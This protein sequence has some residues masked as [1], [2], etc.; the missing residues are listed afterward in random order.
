MLIEVKVRRVIVD[1]HEGHPLVVLQEVGGERMLSIFIGTHDAVSIQRGVWGVPWPRPFTQDVIVSVIEALGGDVYGVEITGLVGNTYHA[2]INV[3]RGSEFFRID[4]R[5]SDAIAIVLSCRPVR[6]IYVEEKLF[7]TTGCAE[8]VRTPDAQSLHIAQDTS[9]RPK[10][11]GPEGANKGQNDAAQGDEGGAPNS[12]ESAAVFVPRRWAFGVFFPPP[13][14]DPRLFARRS[15]LLIE[16]FLD[17]R[18][19][20]KDN[21]PHRGKVAL[22][23]LDECPFPG[24][25]QRCRDVKPT[26]EQGPQKSEGYCC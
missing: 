9:R 24:T 14:V 23:G 25:R 8:D 19:I 26:Q 18:N 2:A 4:A 7:A 20:Y 1:E 22:T 5:P 10:G 16:A 12:D 6:P 21:C 17:D 15:D 11:G 3:R 13:M